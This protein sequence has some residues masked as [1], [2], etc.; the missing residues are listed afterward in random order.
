MKTCMIFTAVCCAADACQQSVFTRHRGEV[1]GITTD[2]RPLVLS[3]SHTGLTLVLVKL[4][5]ADQQ[6][7]WSGRG[8][9]SKKLRISGKPITHTQIF[10]VTLLMAVAFCI[11]MY[12]LVLIYLIYSFIYSYILFVLFIGFHFIL[13]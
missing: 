7:P 2:P 11:F 9:L 5:N 1:T 10:V 6:D 4:R 8:G 12:S 3:V 13:V